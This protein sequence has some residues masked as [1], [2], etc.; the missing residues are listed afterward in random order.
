[1]ERH[2]GDPVENFKERADT[3]GGETEA[4]EWQK[5]LPEM[6][7]WDMNKMEE[8][9]F[10]YLYYHGETA[11][12]R[13][14]FFGNYEYRWGIKQGSPSARIL[15]DSEGGGPSQHLFLAEDEVYITG[16]TGDERIALVSRDPW[17]AQKI[18]CEHGDSGFE[19]PWREDG[20]KYNVNAPNQDR[21]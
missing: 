19:G 8:I 15:I 2:S 13:D 12:L 4:P 9:G 7:E 16:G 6:F 18:I 21:A 14:W 10:E 3:G 5:E 17:R 20:Q 11:K 1:M